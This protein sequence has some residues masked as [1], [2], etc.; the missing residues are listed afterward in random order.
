MATI[1]ITSN[2]ASGAGTLRQAVADAQPGDV[3]TPDPTLGPIEIILT[4]NL[5]VATPVKISGGRERMRINGAGAYYVY[6]S[7]SATEGED[8]TTIEDVDFVALKNTTS[9]GAGS[10]RINTPGVAFKRC[11]VAGCETKNGG[12]FHFGVNVENATFESCALLGNLATTA[13]GAAYFANGK[14][15]VTE[16]VNCT[17]I[18]NLPAPAFNATPTL[19]DCKQTTDGLVAPPPADWSV[20]NWSSTAWES[21]NPHILATSA[22]ARGFNSADED[23]DVE[24]VPRVSGGAIGAYETIEADLYWVGVDANGTPV[25]TPT[26]DDAAGWAADRFATVAG[27]TAPAAALSIFIGAE[28]LTFEDVWNPTEDARL[29]IGRGKVT[30]TIQADAHRVVDARIGTGRLVATGAIRLTD[31]DDLAKVE[32]V[33]PVAIATATPVSF[34]GAF[35]IGQLVELDLQVGGSFPALTIAGGTLK[36]GNTTEIADSL[37]MSAGTIELIDGALL[38]IA[39]ATATITGGT[40]ATTTRGYLSTAPEED[41]SAATFTGNVIRLNATLSLYDFRADTTGRLV[42]FSWTGDGATVLEQVEPYELISAAAESSA[43]PVATASRETIYRL[44]AGPYWLRATAHP[45]V[46]PA[47]WTV[48]PWLT[49]AAEIAGVTYEVDVWGLNPNITHINEEQ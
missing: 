30:A 13:A 44:W 23:T 26:F 25:E 21:W 11:V 45:R 15:E 46:S 3:I 17:L 42:E 18:G 48:E 10:V 20:D 24:G 28:N 4:A 6:L 40:I 35:S 2:A 33:A 5:T 12:A 36:I 32:P 27:T 14:E 29:V 1:Y 8:T 47:F 38:R 43:P 37:T 31:G 22:D 16:F 49:T 39:G 9:A 34:W 7:A 41:W 19:V